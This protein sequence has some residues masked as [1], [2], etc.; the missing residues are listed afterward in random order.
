M[1]FVPY[2][3]RGRRFRDFTFDFHISNETGRLWYDGSPEQFMPERGWCVDHIMPGFTVVDCGAHHGMLTSI[4]AHAV[5]PEGHVIAYEAL[6]E[7]AAVIEKNVELNGFSN[8]VVRPV[9][10]GNVTATVAIDLNASNT[11][12]ATAGTGSGP[13]IQIVRLEDDLARGL[14]VDFL[15]VDVEGH[16]LEALMGMKRILKQRPF[17]DLELHNFLFSDRVTTLN[18]ILKIFSSLDY[19][20]QILPE[21]MGEIVPIDS[22]DVSEIARYD[23]PHVFFTPKAKRPWYK[24]IGLGLT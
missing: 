13:N 1:T 3:A 22:F 21:I 24:Y 19:E 16:D 12:V 10:V 7:N 15:K 11:V 8:V 23:N 5:G 14:R 18:R 6:P 9:G 17:I 4:F 20:M 2:V